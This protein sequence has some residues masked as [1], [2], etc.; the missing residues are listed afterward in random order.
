MLL[1]YQVYTSIILWIVPM[2]EKY[3]KNSKLRKTTRKPAKYVRCRIVLVVNYRTS[4]I[5][6]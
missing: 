2:S 4:K 3:M 1:L 6:K 5:L